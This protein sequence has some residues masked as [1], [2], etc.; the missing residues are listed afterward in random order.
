MRWRPRCC[1]F[2]SC[3]RWCSVRW[4]WFWLIR[5]APAVTAVKPLAT[6][7]NIAPWFAAGGSCHADCRDRQSKRGGGQV[8][9]GHQRGW[10]LRQPGP[11]RDAGRCGPPAIVAPVA[12]PAAR[13]RA[14]H[15]G[16]GRAARLHRA[17]AQGH[18]PRGA[19]HLRRPARHPP[20]R[21]DAPGRQGAGAGAAQHFRHLRHARVFGQGGRSAQQPAARSGHRRHARG[22][23]HHRRRPAA[24]VRR[25]LAPAGAGHAAAHAELRVSGRARADAVRHRP[26]PRGARSGAVAGH[27]RLAG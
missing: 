1:I 16:V 17:P 15:R 19:G 22:R 3:W 18:D 7:A 2:D 24:P 25:R 12:Q 26:R 4:R 11:R 5:A 13:R 9:A 21:G 23:A 20:A 14:P 8:H 6:T 27:L 10:L